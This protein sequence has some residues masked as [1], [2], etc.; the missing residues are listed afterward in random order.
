MRI[1]RQQ[2]EEFSCQGVTPSEQLDYGYMTPNMQYRS[3][4]VR[5]VEDHYLPRII[6]KITGQITVPFG[7]AVVATRDTCIGYEICEELW[8]PER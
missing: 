5:Q 6:S 4:Q 2:D 1:F 3:F 8:N 7:D